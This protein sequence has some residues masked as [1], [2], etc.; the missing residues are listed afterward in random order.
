[1]DEDRSEY[2]GTPDPGKMAETPELND[3]RPGS[4]TSN[5]LADTGKNSKQNHIGSIYAPIVRPIYSCL[6]SH[7]CDSLPLLLPPF[8]PLHI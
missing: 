7:Y 4:A 8:T 1:M 6:D 3:E 5:Q 2:A